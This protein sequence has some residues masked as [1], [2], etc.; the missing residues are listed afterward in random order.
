[1]RLLIMLCTVSLVLQQGAFAQGQSAAQRR[2]ELARVQE[3]VNDPD[4]LMRI[5]N[6]EEIAAEGDAA[7]LQIA[8][9]VA[10]TGNDRSLRGIAFKAFLAGV[11]RFQAELAI[12]PAIQKRY[13]AAVAEGH[14]AVRELNA[15]YRS[16]DRLISN[17]AMR[18]DFRVSEMDM[19]SGRGKARVNW[20]FRGDRDFDFQVNGD[21]LIATVGIDSTSPGQSCPMEL[22]P[23]N[24]LR[25]AGQLRCQ[26]TGFGTVKISAPMY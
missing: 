6:F 7:K 22:M 16:L 18:A 25:I 23:T 13:D 21:R 17:T 10:L 26:D 12:D 4:P 5:A 2:D 20:Y 3:R 8:I 11:R 15:Q 14:R 24:D 9:K 19:R 1:M